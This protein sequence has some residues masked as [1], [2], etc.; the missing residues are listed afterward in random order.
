MKGIT[1]AWLSPSGQLITKYNNKPIDPDKYHHQLAGYILGTNNKNDNTAALE[2]KGWIRLNTWRNNPTQWII[3][4]WK[5][6]TKAQEQTILSWCLDNNMNY[7]DV[8]I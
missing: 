7:N 5:R 1:N 8:V 6:L 2:N 4:Q 3:P